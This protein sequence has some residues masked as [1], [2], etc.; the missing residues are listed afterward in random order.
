MRTLSIFDVQ[1]INSLLKEKQ[2][3]YILK[4]KD[5]CG[6][7]AISLECTG[8]ESPIQDICD[9]INVFLKTKYIQVSPGT[10]NPLQLQVK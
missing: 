1:D 4:L 9:V 6:N 3:D 10:I 7:Q 8:K 5:A 2:F